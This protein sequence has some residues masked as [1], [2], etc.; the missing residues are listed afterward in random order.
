MY[1]KLAKC[2]NFTYVPEKI[3]KIPK[4]YIILVRKMTQ[5]YM[6]IAREIFSP[7]FGGHVPPVPCPRLLRL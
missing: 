4:F 2:P 7:N 6:I 5:F 3:N 1:E